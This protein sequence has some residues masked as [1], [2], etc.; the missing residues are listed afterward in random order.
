[1]TRNFCKDW[2]F[3]RAIKLKT[4]VYIGICMGHYPSSKHVEIYQNLG[5]LPHT[6]IH[7]IMKLKISL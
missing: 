7:H 2:T 4:K 6:T 3:I 5:D 1:M